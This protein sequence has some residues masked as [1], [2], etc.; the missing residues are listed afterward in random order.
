[1]E[2]GT[3]LGALHAAI[4][5]EEVTTGAERKAVRQ[6][7]AEELFWCNLHDRPADWR[8]N[9]CGG[10]CSAVV[11]NMACASVVDESAVD[12]IQISHWWVSNRSWLSVVD[13]V[14]PIH[15]TVADE[16]IAREEYLRP[17]LA[18]KINKNID[19]SIGYVVKSLCQLRCG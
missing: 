7:L 18:W 10:G 4:A 15:L 13:S 9:A 5:G 17:L 8:D 14:Q 12:L 11:S 2:A 16:G 3:S 6:V 19:Q 1:M